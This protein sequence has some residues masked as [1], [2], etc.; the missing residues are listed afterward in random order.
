[1]FTIGTDPPVIAGSVGPL[2]DALLTGDLT[3][4]VDVDQSHPCYVVADVILLHPGLPGLQ[5]KPETSITTSHS[6]GKSSYLS[7]QSCRNEGY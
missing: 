4:Q 5:N 6:V 3:W 7:K 1:M 2:E